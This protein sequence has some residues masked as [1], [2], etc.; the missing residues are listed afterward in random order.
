M[1]ADINS[2]DRIRVM[3]RTIG[4]SMSFFPSPVWDRNYLPFI[5]ES[6]SCLDGKLESDAKIPYPV[7]FHT[8]PIVRLNSNEAVA[9]PLVWL[10]SL[11]L[12][13]FRCYLS[14]WMLSF[15]VIYLFRCHPLMLLI[16]RYYLSMLFISLD[17]IL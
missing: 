13:S 9:G 16:S 11:C 5:R 8:C 4:L 2:I 7:I 6:F 12:S 10:L 1:Y 14:L 17:V 15:D 3:Y